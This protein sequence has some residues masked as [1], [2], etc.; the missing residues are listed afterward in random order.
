MKREPLAIQAVVASFFYSYR[1]GELHTNHSNMLRSILYDILHQSEAF[2]YHFQSYYREA[3]L[4]GVGCQWP[5]DSLKK[6]LFSIKTHPVQQRLYLIVD[7]MDESDDNGRLSTIKLLRQLRATT[8]S[9]ITKIFLAS[10][11]ITGLNQSL[12]GLQKTIKLQDVNEG[13]ILMFAE[14]FLDQ[15]L[16]LT[17]THLEEAKEY[18][19]KNAQ[20][21]F[22]WVHLVKEEL[23][24]F[25]AK[26]YT[27]K[28]IF[29]FLQSLPTELGGFYERML[30]ELAQND[31]R[32]INIGV[33]M[34]QIVLFAYRPL[35]VAELQHALAIPD[36]LDAQFL[37]SDKTFENELIMLIENR[38][39]HCGG[40]FLEIKGNNG[41]YLFGF[42]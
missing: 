38:I 3:L 23:N 24:K 41:A 5:Y 19:T 14:S 30:Q 36:D 9:C 6:I 39:I 8:G 29:D 37:T 34:F 1:D 18:I 40:N 15:N 16:G 27:P 7:A 33:R 22:V 10:R 26:G 17:P 21:V 35:Q 2:F 42:K 31:Q 11:P 4:P 12:A 32:D 25:A 13:D 20:G 28:E